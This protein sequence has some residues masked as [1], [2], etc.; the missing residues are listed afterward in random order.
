MGPVWKRQ[1][2]RGLEPDLGLLSTGNFMSGP[3]CSLE[4]RANV[5]SHCIFFSW[6][7]LSVSHSQTMKKNLKGVLPGPLA[8]FA[9]TGLLMGKSLNSL[10]PTVLT[11]KNATCLP[12]LMLPI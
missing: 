9:L 1:W 12:Q 4:P 7:E 8:S 11:Q 2:D 3:F 10:H 6:S 5:G